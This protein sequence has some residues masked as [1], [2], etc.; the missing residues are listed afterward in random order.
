M[1]VGKANIINEPLTDHERNH[2]STF[3]HQARNEKAVFKA[4]GNDG[5][6]FEYI[7]RTHHRLSIEKLKVGI[8]DGPQFR[9]LIKM[10][11]P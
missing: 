11:I 1:T 6:C 4:L 2:P 5:D 3:A 7:F 8:F 10:Q 9:K